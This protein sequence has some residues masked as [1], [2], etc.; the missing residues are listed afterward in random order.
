[1][2]CMYLYAYVCVL[3]LFYFIHLIIYVRDKH[4]ALHCIMSNSIVPKCY[5]VTCFAAPCL[6]N[7]FLEIEFRAHRPRFPAHIVMK[8]YYNA[9]L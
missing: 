5:T 2:F 1:M 3:F 8:D 4:K 7:Y 6:D 9:F